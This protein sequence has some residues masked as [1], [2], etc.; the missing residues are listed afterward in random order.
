MFTSFENWWYG[1]A[2]IGCV[3]N[4]SLHKTSEKNEP[5]NLLWTVCYDIYMHAIRHFQWYFI[6]SYKIWYQ[7]YF[8]SLL[9]SHWQRNR[10]RKKQQHTN[11]ECEHM[12]DE[13]CIIHS[14]K[15][16][17]KLQSRNYL[18]LEEYRKQFYIILAY[19]NFKRKMKLFL[20]INGFSYFLP[21]QNTHARIS[22]EFRLAKWQR[23]QNLNHIPKLQLFS[24]RIFNIAKLLHFT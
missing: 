18:P 1:N 23:I 21:S 19:V 16:L 5:T 20:L 13:M 17:F 8:V 10:R 24:F 9:K 22:H 11:T 3:I 4:C 7:F 12:R 14:I 2:V 6:I 15:G